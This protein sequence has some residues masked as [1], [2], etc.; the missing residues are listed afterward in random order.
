MKS[1]CHKNKAFQALL[2]TNYKEI[3][4]ICSIFCYM[5]TMEVSFVH[6]NFAKIY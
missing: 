5:Q 2:Q 3:C 6:P 4:Y 1:L